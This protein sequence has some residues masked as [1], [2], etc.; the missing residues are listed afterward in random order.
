MQLNDGA[1]R[2]GNPDYLADT[3][4]S[5]RIPGEGGFDLQ[6]C[7]SAIRQRGWQGPF[8]VEVLSERLRALPPD[9]VCRRL[10]AATKT[11]LA[12]PGDS[13]GKVI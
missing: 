3:T 12:G 2:P 9:Q 8:S 10:Y 11:L 5:R 4:S 6:R 1:L 13:T 7:V